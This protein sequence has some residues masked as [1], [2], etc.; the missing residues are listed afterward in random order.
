MQKK[1]NKVSLYTRCLNGI[2]GVGNRLPDP[3]ALF[4]VFSLAIVLI[5]AICAA[6]DIRI[7]A[8]V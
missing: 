8:R 1:T 5:S 4:A 7:L 3:I 2:E 6:M